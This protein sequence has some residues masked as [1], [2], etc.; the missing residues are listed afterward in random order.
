MVTFEVLG[1]A[2]CVPCK[3]LKKVLEELEYDAPFSIPRF[4]W[5][6]VDLYEQPDLVNKFDIAS[7]PVLVAGD[8]VLLRGMLPKDKLVTLMKEY[9]E[10]NG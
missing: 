8:D 10:R 9:M 2:G 7:V 6:Y 5:K 1:M 3:N 4:K